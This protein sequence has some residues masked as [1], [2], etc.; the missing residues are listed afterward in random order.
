MANGQ[1]RKVQ[2][3]N[4]QHAIK[5]PLDYRPQ[6]HGEQ[7]ATCYKLAGDC[8]RHGKWPKR[9][10]SQEQSV[11]VTCN[12]SSRGGWMARVPGS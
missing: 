3:C 2:Q 6:D 12:I 5:G 9:D 4:T 7:H 11:T 10:E 1:V 8:A